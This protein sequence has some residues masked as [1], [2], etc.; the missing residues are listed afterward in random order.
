MK[1]VAMTKT[2]YQ[3]KPLKCT[4]NK[5]STLRTRSTNHGRTREKQNKAS[6]H[7]DI[8]YCSFTLQ[9]VNYCVKMQLLFV[10]EFLSINLCICDDL[11]IL[12]TSNCLERTSEMNITT[13]WKRYSYIHFTFI[14]T[15]VPR[16]SW[17]EQLSRKQGG[18]VIVECVKKGEGGGGGGGEGGGGGGG[19]GGG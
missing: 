13:D 8:I 19:G 4:R 6:L 7:E 10:C 15:S 5:L 9:I 17:T 11:Y 18:S 14:S 16:I 1:K 3:G 2:S 12:T